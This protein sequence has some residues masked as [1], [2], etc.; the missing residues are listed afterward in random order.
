MKTIAQI[1][2]LSGDPTESVTYTIQLKFPANHF[3]YT[4][5]ETMIVLYRQV[6]V[7]FKYVNPPTTHGTQRHR[8]TDMPA[9]ARRNLRPRGGRHDD[10]MNRDRF[11]ARPYAR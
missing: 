5:R 6:T 9:V 7:E 8:R 4:V 1:A 2:V 10:V 3:V 11:D